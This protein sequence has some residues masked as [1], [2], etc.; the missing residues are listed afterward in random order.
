MSTPA[1]G[2]D[3]RPRAAAFFDVDNTIIRGASSFHIARS[4]RQH[5][6]FRRRDILRFGFEQAKYQL[7][8]ESDAQM[9]VLKRDAANII[10]GWSVAEMA[11]I[12]EGVWDEVLA[13]RVYP[14][15]KALIDGHVAQGHEVW[16]VTATPKEVGQIIDIRISRFFLPIF[17]P[18]AA[19]Y[20]S[21]LI[22]MKTYS[23]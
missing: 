22:K 13:A 18:A 12:G 4:M 21:C 16:L 20:Q 8:G 6:F 23:N 11:A 9:Q 14:G 1:A 17:T 19:C 2:D 7:F 15:T 3:A 10:R 5:G